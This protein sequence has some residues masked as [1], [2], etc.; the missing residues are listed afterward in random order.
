MTNRIESDTTKMEKRPRASVLYTMRTWWW[1]RDPNTFS[2]CNVDCRIWISAD[3]HT[4][5][6]WWDHAAH[7]YVR[8][9]DRAK[10][11][12]NT[13]ESVCCASTLDQEE[14]IMATMLT[15]TSHGVVLL[16]N[17]KEWWAES[18]DRSSCAWPSAAAQEILVLVTAW[19]QQRFLKSLL[20]RTRIRVT[21]DTRSN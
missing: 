16:R 17:N 1:R 7:V 6:N 5:G 14:A 20:S 13:M 8:V 12:C 10:A 3:Y 18:R 4:G 15:Q 21:G 9:Q 11:G 19:K 2:S